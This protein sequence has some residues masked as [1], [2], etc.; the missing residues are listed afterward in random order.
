MASL[1]R[2]AQKKPVLGRTGCKDP[3]DV[4]AADKGKEEIPMCLL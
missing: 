3:L 2:S 1:R 4:V